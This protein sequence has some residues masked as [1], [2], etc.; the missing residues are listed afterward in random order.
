MKCANLY[1]F[2]N[3]AIET[4]WKNIGF[5]WRT[6][7]AIPARKWVML[8]DWTTLD[9][10]KVKRDEWERA[11]PQLVV[12]PAARVLTTMRERIPYTFPPLEDGK[13]RKPTRAVKEAMS[14]VRGN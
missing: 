12:Y 10:A 8:V 5:G 6:V 13:P 1:R 2:Y 14:V 11:K 3:E 9:V 4:G 7:I